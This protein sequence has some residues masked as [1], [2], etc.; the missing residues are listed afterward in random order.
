MIQT[1]FWPEQRVVTGVLGTIEAVVKDAGIKPPATLVIG[2]V[3]ALRDVLGGR[4]S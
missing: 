3:V 2:D 4:S 1:A